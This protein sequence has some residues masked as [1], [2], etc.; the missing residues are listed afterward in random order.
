MGRSN[1][2]APPMR[3]RSEDDRSR[4]ELTLGERYV[5][6]PGIAH[7]G[8]LAACFDQICGHRATEA[9]HPG[10]T[11]ELDVR[12]LRPARVHV[13]LAFEAG[14][15]AVSGRRVTVE[16]TCRREGETLAT[17]R[18]TFVVIDHGHGARLFRGG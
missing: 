10:L 15:T 12:Y 4:C 13:E 16:A 9:G 14:V 3:V 11:V 17:C 1:P 18:A 2:V 5:G 8:V 6:A 7:G